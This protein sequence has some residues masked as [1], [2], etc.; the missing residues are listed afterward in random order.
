MPLS[1]NNFFDQFEFVP[2][3]TCD[4]YLVDVPMNNVTVEIE[5]ATNKVAM[6]DY[7][8]LTKHQ[9]IFIALYCQESSDPNCSFYYLINQFM[10]ERKD[11][12]LCMRSALYLLESGL[13]SLPPIEDVAWRGINIAPDLKKFVVGRTVCFSGICSTSVD[14]DQTLQFMKVPPRLG[15]HK[16]TLF[17]LHMLNGVSIQKWSPWKQ[18]QEVV[19]SFCSCWEVIEVEQNQNEFFDTIGPYHCDYYIELRQLPSEPLFRSNNVLTGLYLLSKIN[20]EKPADLSTNFKTKFLDFYHQLAD[21]NAQEILELV[22]LTTNYWNKEDKNFKNN[23][24]NKE[25][26]DLISQFLEGIRTLSIE[27]QHHGIDLPRGF[28]IC[29]T[30]QIYAAVHL[31]YDKNDGGERTIADFEGLGF[32]SEW[33][34]KL[35]NQE[36]VK[37]ELQILYNRVNYDGTVDSPKNVFNW[38]TRARFKHY[39]KRDGIMVSIYE[40]AHGSLNGAKKL[41]PKLRNLFNGSIQFDNFKVL[42]KTISYEIQYTDFAIAGVIF[43]VQ[44]GM[45]SFQL[46][47]GDITTR[48][49]LKSISACAVAVGTGFVGGFAAGYFVA[50]I[51]VLLGITAW[52]ATIAVLLGTAVGGLAC[53][54]GADLLF[55]YLSEKFFPDG[56]DEELNAQRKLYC[57][58]LE[59]LACNPDSTMRN[60]QQAYYRK[61]QATHPDKCDNKKVAEED[62]KTLVAAYEIA[63]NYHEVLEDACKTLNISNQFTVDDL[64]ACKSTITDNSELKRAYNIAYRHIVYSANK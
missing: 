40:I 10:R 52:P 2:Q 3:F 24:E 8:G 55:R 29:E 61:A 50:G 33:A 7:D 26:F 13:R 41:C 57:A 12:L 16:R 59:T 46:W 32:N 60:I 34:T 36:H 25:I 1:E 11:Q 30:H 53:G 44:F 20:F 56:E 18:E 64:K 9:A 22:L 28:E 14:K 6:M 63:K 15:I 31:L 27:F 19:A 43:A 35:Y 54:G 47:H 4:Q 51:A 58:A 62:F 49:F 21:A 17:K 5:K 45:Y 38:L 39:I 37:Q 48:Q 23:P 42:G